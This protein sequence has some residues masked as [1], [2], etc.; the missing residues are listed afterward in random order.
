MS[1]CNCQKFMFNYK[2]LITKV[3][4][5]H[6]R[7]NPM[8]EIYFP[9]WLFT[10]LLTQKCAFYCNFSK[11]CTQFKWC[12]V[13][14]RIQYLIRRTYFNLWNATCTKNEID[15]PY[16]KRRAKIGRSLIFNLNS[17]ASKFLTLLTKT[18]YM[19]LKVV[20]GK[21]FQQ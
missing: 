12:S 9:K 10:V 6:I 2:L 8:R 17:F 21:V 20:L 13:L 14:K 16:V 15:I 7:F 5:Y 1:T 18:V 11:L 19:Y 3:I 4:T